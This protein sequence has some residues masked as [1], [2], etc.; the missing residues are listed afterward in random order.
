M[1]VL[2]SWIELVRLCGDI[3]VD[4]GWRDVLEVSFG[5]FFVLG[6]FGFE[7]GGGC[8]LV[9]VCFC[10][11]VQGGVVVVYCVVGI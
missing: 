4:D 6:V 9:C 8:M 11:V 7:V 1:V 5:W 2:L 3:M 10:V